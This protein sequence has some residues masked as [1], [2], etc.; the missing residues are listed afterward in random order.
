[1][2][3]LNRKERIRN[4]FFYYILP[5]TLGFFIL[6]LI[7]YYPYVASGKSL[8]WNSDG[9]NQHYPSLVY[10]GRYLH[11]LITGGEVPMIDF[12]LGM[13]FDVLTTLNYYAIGDPLALLTIF[14]NESNAEMIYGL[15]IM[16][17]LYLSGI[18]Y[19]IYCIYRKQNSYPSVLGAFIYVFCGYVFYAGVRHPYFTN[20]LIYLPFLFLGIELIF[21]KKKPYLF[22]IMTCI[23]ALSNFYF[24]YMLT[25]IVVIYSAYRFFC[26]YDKR[27]SV[28]V[29]KLFFK[30]A[31]QTSFFYLVGIA[32]SG[33]IMLPVLYAFF[34]NG[35]FLSG[36]DVNL[37]HYSPGYYIR[38][39]HG[40]IAPNIEAGFWTQ[41]AYAAIIPAIVLIV[42]RNKKYR[43]QLVIF[44]IGT[45]SLLLPFIGYFMNGFAYVSNRWEFGYC[46]LIA[47]LFT[48]AYEDLFHLN[49]I[50]KI[51]LISGTLLYGVLGVFNPSIYILYGFAFLCLTVA[52]IL[53]FNKHKEKTILQK[54]VI[55]VLI[56]LNLGANGYL[57]Y[58]EGF[59]NYVGEFIDG[60]MV[61]SNIRNSPVSMADK[62]SDESFYRIEVY[63]DKLY[64]EGMVLGFRD[65]S[66]YF[67]IMDRRL[68]EFMKDLELVS[69][70]AA[71]RF[72]NMDYRSGLSALAGVK[73]LVTSSKKIAPYGYQLIDKEGEG[74]K[75]YYLYENQLALPLGY[76]YQTYITRETYEKLNTVQKQEILL[77]A[78]LLETKIDYLSE[79]T[80]NGVNSNNQNR[81]SSEQLPVTIQYG[82]GITKE[83]DYIN[84][85]EAGAKI[86]VTF[87]GRER[88][89]TYLRLEGF[90]INKTNYYAINV[91]IKGKNKISKTIYSRSN[92]NNAY[93]G[94]EDYLINLGYQKKPMKSCQ[95]IFTKPGLFQLRDILVYSLPMSEY[96]KQIQKRKEYVLGD[97][98]LY[99]N[100]ITGRYNCSENSLLC[101]SI[102]YSKG[103]TA[104]VDG[105][106]TDL[107]PANV[108]YMALS[109]RA[110]DHEIELYYETPYLKEGMMLS[111]AGVILFLCILFYHRD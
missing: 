57:T 27:N 70:K 47:F 42:L 10:Y 29:W 31:F 97:I 106:R 15:L 71:Y 73:Y 24:L 1:M 79:L 25:I 51:L 9:I 3:N 84:V 93:F 78:A 53:I 111:A 37:I 68:T 92:Q 101:L 36:Y 52:L 65:V 58:A 64:N 7:A 91:K 18:S 69:Q 99:N 56:M 5:F 59:G 63:G 110:G 100:R 75:T 74:D 20:P 14:V 44:H 43:R 28:P 104:Y 61:D 23:S 41:T 103:W 67:S 48:Y 72:D 17:R 87:E 16:L 49:K 11:N 82:K 55:A 30:T 90:H 76:G 32:M 102:P 98:R 108:M 12:N 40:F 54:T 45:V 109:V 38:F 95:I 6:L 62:I 26:T 13:G 46:F 81:F 107:V 105:E 33:V 77:Q 35:R 22:I 83:G 39:L 50:D 85:E 94:K 86:T 34:Q 88:S 4:I 19:L 60:G 89:E 66:G 80:V 96:E 8:V 21:Q 2:P